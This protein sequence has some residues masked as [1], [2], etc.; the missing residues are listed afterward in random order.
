MK[1]MMMI[2]FNQAEVVSLSRSWVIKIYLGTKT[3]INIMPK[4][5]HR[6]NNFVKIDALGF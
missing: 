3:F 1:V 6:L 4:H 2:D 5:K